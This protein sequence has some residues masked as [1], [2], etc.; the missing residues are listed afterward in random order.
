[1]SRRAR[2]AVDR[3]ISSGSSLRLS[4]LRK[5]PA[6]SAVVVLALAFGLGANTALFLLFNTVLLGAL[7][8]EHPE[9]LVVLSMA[10]ENSESITSFSYPMYR[11]L[12]DKNAV[13]TGMIAQAGA[14]M[15][16]THAGGSGKARGDLVTGNYFETLGVQPWRDDFFQADN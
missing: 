11:E 5:S 4:P 9:Q 7:P 8:V 2:R 16:A 12:R 6:F 1:M 3:R 10:N 13:F 14:E 15:N